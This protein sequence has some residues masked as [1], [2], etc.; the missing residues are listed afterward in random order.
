MPFF[1]KRNLEKNHEF[2]T[3]VG[4]RK[5]SIYSQLRGKSPVKRVFSLWTEVSRKRC[6]F[7][8]FRGCHSPVK[9]RKRNLNIKPVKDKYNLICFPST[10]HTYW[11]VICTRKKKEG[12]W[13]DSVS[14]IVNYWMNF[15]ICDLN[16]FSRRRKKKRT[17]ERN[18]C[19]ILP[20]GLILPVF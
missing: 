15:V 16:I 19:L 9:K 10:L 13:K 8:R 14:S 1:R 12:N 20:V 3:E 2:G 18:L 4:K 5:T 11:K 7:S 17:V 6:W